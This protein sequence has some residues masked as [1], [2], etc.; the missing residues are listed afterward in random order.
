[1]SSNTPFKIALVGNPNLGKTTLFNRLCGLNQ[2]T[3]NYPGV[4]IDKKKGFLKSGDKNVE[5]IDL[6]GI[7][8]LFPSSKDEELVVDYLLN[9]ENA[10]YPNKIVLIVS[11]LNLKRNL[12]L[13]E[14]IRD[15]NIPIV[16]A[17]NMADLAEK[18][19]VFIAEKALEKELGVPVVK[20]SAKKGTGVDAL[21]GRCME[22]SVIE[23]RAPSYIEE[24]ELA[25]LEKY[26]AKEGL[27][28]NY[29]GFLK[30][31]TAAKSEA[32]QEF[33]TENNLNVRKW[34]T[35]AS[36]LRYK[37]INSY[38]DK[39]LTVD[40]SKASDFTTKLDRVLLHPVFGYVIFIGVLLVIFQAIF[41]LADFPMG[42]IET[43][44]EWLQSAASAGLPEGYF[45]RLITE[46]LIPGIGGVVI[47]VPQITILFFLF[48]LLEESGYMSRIVYLTDRLMQGF[49]MSGKSIVPM[50]SGLACAVPAIM[51][52]RTIENSRE[53]LITILVTPLLTCAAR[54]PVYVVV[55]ALII[56]DD[57]TV[58]G[59]FN[60]QGI[61][62]MGLYLL[63]VVMTFIV[64][65]VLKYL[66]KPSYKSYLLM[67]VPEYLLPGMK[68]VLIRVWTNVKSFIW[69]AGKIIFATAV[70][71]FVLVTNGG[72]D[73]KNT[74]QYITAQYPTLAADEKNDLIASYQTE[75][76]Y[77]GML[78]KTIEPA[79]EP[80]G[81]DWKIGIA[82]ISS[83]AARE[84]F[85]GTISVIYA[86]GSE[87]EMNVRDRLKAEVNPHTGMP[88]FGLATSISLLLFYA[89]SLQ[90]MSTVAV[91]Y[92]ETKSVKW[93]AIQFGYM[94]VLAYFS[95]LIAYQLLK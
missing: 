17:I 19:G 73:F 62:L 45:S 3:G 40:K 61:A 4:T 8:S 74:E 23:E 88:A 94:T 72:D 39:V 79:I 15:I 9:T 35:N 38:L 64:A 92:K 47:F 22:T 65:F 85:V 87:E 36:I 46:G 68:N 7:N 12:Y 5:V 43:A 66:L 20:I 78:G 10:E 89:F 77:L 50:I 34:K 27:A 31:T 1:M 26:S 18:R 52:A 93:T 32:T 33:I 86:V 58:F 90:C 13:F 59:I 71:L 76:S 2:R 28:N 29:I 25:V 83:L 37:R 63:G 91:T 42:W 95:A 49:G 24:E 57:A 84:V 44:F 81:Y 21:I 75:N 41:W 11:A 69:N 70:I 14:Q 55:I 48:S 16:L 51:A 67:E 82:L 54:I 60:A 6:P 80:L 30:L 56:P 53:R